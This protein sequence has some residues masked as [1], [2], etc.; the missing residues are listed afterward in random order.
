MILN[1]YTSTAI[2]SKPLERGLQSI[3]IKPP[4]RKLEVQR[5]ILCDCGK[6]AGN[7][8][9]PLTYHCSDCRSIIRVSPG[10]GR[11]EFTEQQFAEQNG[12]QALNV[13]RVE[14]VSDLSKQLDP[15]SPEE[16]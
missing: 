3:D 1:E 16:Y 11:V 5:P 8:G 12:A 4:E 13:E 6:R 15:L 9:L 14:A 10:L 2:G 7:I